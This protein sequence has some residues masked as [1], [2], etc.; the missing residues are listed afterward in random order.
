MNVIKEIG[1]KKIV[2]VII[3]NAYVMKVVDFLLKLSILIFF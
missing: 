1:H 3:D 2:Q